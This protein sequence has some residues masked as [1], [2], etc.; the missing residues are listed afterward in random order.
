MA[1]HVW[2]LDEGGAVD[3]WQL[4]SGYCNGPR[5]AACDESF[6]HHCTDID[7]LDDC[8]SVIVVMEQRQQPH[9]PISAP[10]IG[11]GSTGTGERALGAHSDDEGMQDV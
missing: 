5:C 1:K 9:A 6:C 7:A 10:Q 8:A 2:I 4:E 11:P 3:I